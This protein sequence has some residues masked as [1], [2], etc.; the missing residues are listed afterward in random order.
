MTL[1]LTYLNGD[2]IAGLD[3]PDERLLGAVEAVLATHGRGETVV[4]P[5]VHLFPDPAVEGH[6]NVLRGAIPGARRAGV[7]VVGDYVRNHQGG[8]RRSSPC[9]W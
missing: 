3:Y 5:R 6:F 9:C 2:D 1:D 7:K 8:C 4:E